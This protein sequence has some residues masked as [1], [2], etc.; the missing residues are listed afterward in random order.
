M[1]EKKTALDLA[2]EWR[3]LWKQRPWKDGT[4]DRISDI[5]AIFLAI[6]ADA[7]EQLKAKDK[8]LALLQRSLSDSLLNAHELERGLAA[9]NVE[10]E[11]LRGCHDGLFRSFAQEYTARAEK[12]EAGYAAREKQLGQRALRLREESSKRIKAEARIVE[13]EDTIRSSIESASAYIC[14]RPSGGP[15]DICQ[16][17]AVTVAALDKATKC[18]VCSKLEACAR[19]QEAR[20][21]E[22]EAEVKI[23]EA[24]VEALEDAY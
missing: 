20:V 19:E 2:C 16:S 10:I 9:R 14:V 8:G 3:E 15:E 24:E 5:D 12:A 23:L 18:D 13:L 1:G 6:P 11:R 7:P 21:K 4:H 17:L 22:L